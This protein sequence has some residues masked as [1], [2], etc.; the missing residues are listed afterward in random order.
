[1]VNF[2]SSDQKSS[3]HGIGWC[4]LFFLI[5]V[6]FPLTSLKFLSKR[7]SPTIRTSEHSAVT[8]FRNR[9][10]VTS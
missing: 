6:Y 8:E 7:S 2:D 1:M 4:D 10:I 9:I 3:N 5:F